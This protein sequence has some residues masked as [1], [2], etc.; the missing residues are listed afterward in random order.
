MIKKST[1]TIKSETSSMA[2]VRNEAKRTHI[3]PIVI[4]T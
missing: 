3:L 2:K 4:E 1:W